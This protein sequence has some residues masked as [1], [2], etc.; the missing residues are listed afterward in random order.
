MPKLLLLNNGNE[1]EMKTKSSRRCNNESV[2]C[3]LLH[4]STLT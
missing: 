3:M 4:Y 2:E 1:N